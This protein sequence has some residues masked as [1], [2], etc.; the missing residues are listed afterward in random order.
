MTHWELH[1]ESKFVRKEPCPSC[2]SR[3]NL[4]RYD[5]GHAW[6]F[7][8]GYREPKDEER[9]GESFGEQ[10]VQTAQSGEPKEVFTIQGEARELKKRAIRADTCAFW[11]YTLGEFNGR[12]AQFANYIDPVTRRPIA[13]KLRFAD[14]SF[15]FIGDTK[16]V[17]LY[18]QWLWRDGGKMVVVCEGEIDALSVS[19]VQGNKWAT[20]SVPNGA[21]GAAKAIRKSMEW[22]NR[23]DTVVFMFDMDDPGRA[24]AIECAKLLQPGKAKIAYLNNAKDANELLQQGRDNEIID[25]IWSAQVYRP[26]GIVSGVDLLDRVRSFGVDHGVSYP[27]PALTEK[28]GGIQKRSLITITAG[29]GIGKSAFCR[30][31]AYDLLMNKKQKVGYI[32]LEESP[33]RTLIGLMG[34]HVNRPL[35]LNR[36]VVSPEEFDAAFN[37]VTPDLSLFDSFGSIEP[38]N[39]IERLRYLAVGMECDVLFL[40]HISIAISGLE[41]I[42]ERR[43]LDVMMTRLRSLVEETG[44]TMFIVSHL[45]RPQG[46]KGHEMGA[47][48]SLSALRGSHAIAQLSDMV[49]GLERNQQGDNPNETIV[50]VL[51]N[52]FSGET[53]EAC[54]L[55]YD[56]FT[57]RLTENNVKAVVYDDDAP[58]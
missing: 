27:F 13:A 49:I 52:R 35:H 45:R 53:G 55:Y 17:G 7:G 48:T 47:M 57:G 19:Q 18:G 44:V 21:Q 36:D 40:D 3:D 26:D 33:E 11:S 22:L 12:P 15:S 10:T 46:D 32:A 25:A 24:A 1:E 51:K 30:E 34:I 6:C 23:F 16:S 2:G 8:C 5:D 43:A 42:D 58:F 37:A 29:S 56:K 4:G 38:D 41:D 50:R 20:V 31:L 28:T 54:T 9:M 14:K 39:L